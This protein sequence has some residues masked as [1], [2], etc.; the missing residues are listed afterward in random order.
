ML[1]DNVQLPVDRAFFSTRINKALQHREN[2]FRDRKHYRL[3]NAEG[4][5]LP[6][7]VC[8]KYDDVLCVN[9][10][11]AAMEILYEDVVVEALQLIMA[12]RA[13][14]VRY[15]GTPDRQLEMAQ[16]RAPIVARGHYDSP[17][18]VPKEE[19]GGLEFELDLLAEDVSSGRFLA[20]R[21]LRDLVAGALRGPSPGGDPPRVLSLF[22]ESV[23]VACAVQGAHVHCAEGLGEVRRARTEALALRIVPASTL[24]VEPVRDCAELKLGALS[25]VSETRRS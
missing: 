22:G 24:S 7:I 2:F 12:P 5:M 1:A 11:S 21:A 10:S 25:A 18:V 15:D 13:I 20:D 9:F 8:D 6:G 3:L 16:V 14:I 4:D 23:G 17:T 19:A